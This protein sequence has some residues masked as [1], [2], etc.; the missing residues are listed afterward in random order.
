MKSRTL[1]L[2]N[3]KGG[4]KKCNHI[5]GQQQT[6]TSII[7]FDK[8][9]IYIYIYCIALQKEDIVLFSA[10]CNLLSAGTLQRRNS[11]FFLYERIC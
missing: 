10:S 6:V 8:L 7:I 9:V 3:N 5:Q 4:C 2:L 1:S 11:H